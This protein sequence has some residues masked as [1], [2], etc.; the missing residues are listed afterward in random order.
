MMLFL[1]SASTACC[2]KE[3]IVRKVP[4]SCIDG[5]SVPVKVGDKILDGKEDGCPSPYIRCAKPEQLH[6]VN[7]RLEALWRY[8]TATQTQCKELDQ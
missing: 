3:V 1:A 5:I 7:E 2:K 4:V 6:T 8:V